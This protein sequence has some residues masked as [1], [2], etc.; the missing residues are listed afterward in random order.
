MFKTIK[1]RIE[2]FFRKKVFEQ[3]INITSDT[4]EDMDIENFLQGHMDI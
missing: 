3:A 2:S 1:N 4:I